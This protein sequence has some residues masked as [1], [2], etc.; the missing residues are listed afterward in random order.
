VHKFLVEAGGCA[1]ATGAQMNAPGRFIRL[2]AAILAAE[3]WARALK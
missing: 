2:V 1:S 3:P